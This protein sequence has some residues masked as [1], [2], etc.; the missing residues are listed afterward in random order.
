VSIRRAVRA[1]LIA[2]GVVALFLYPGRSSG[3]DF[4]ETYPGLRVTPFVSERIEYETNIFQAPSHSQ[5]DVIFRTMPGILLECGTGNNTLSAGYRAEILNFN[6]LTDQDAVHHFFAGQLELE[7]NRLRVSVR[8]DFAYTTDPPGTELTG[9]IRSTTNTFTPSVRYRVSERFSIGANAS[10]SHVDFPTISVLTREEY[11]GGASVFWHFLPKAAVE[12]N[13]NY[14]RKEFDDRNLRDVDRHFVLV[15]LTGEITPKFSSTFRMGW[16]DRES[17]RPGISG[18]NGYVMGGDL[19]YRPVTQLSITLSADR[20]AQESSFANEPYYIATMGT[21]VVTYQLGPKLQ[22]NVRVTGGNNS[23]PGRETVNG[24]TKFRDDT[25]VGWGG[26][27]FYDIQKWLRVSLDYQHTL[28]DS[29]FPEFSFQDDKVA[30]TITL[31][32]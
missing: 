28:R 21:L 29:N 17:Q 6:R 7:F 24:Q 18:Y 19:T 9:R 12:L 1:S 32:F 5:D 13:Y 15:A 30:G 22:F 8:D 10:W 2:C 26:G 31:Q 20:S 27:V 14:G 25:L 16:E 4:S 3:L 23:Y 11:F